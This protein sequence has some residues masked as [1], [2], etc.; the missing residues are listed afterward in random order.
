MTVLRA[1]AKG[2]GKLQLES[3]S[4]FNQPIADDDL[5]H[6]VAMNKLNTFDLYHVK[7]GDAGMIYVAQFPRLKT[8][9]LRTNVGDR[10]LADLRN[11]RQLVWLDLSE[12]PVTDAGMKHLQSLENLHYLN[13]GGTQITDD[14][15]L[16]LAGLSSLESLRLSGG[17][18]GMH[19]VTNVDTK[20]TDKGVQELQK[21]LP[22]CK[23]ER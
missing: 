20:V 4:I 9:S 5:R 19:G 22:K 11:A 17:E 14:G 13:L 7:V 16:A 12:T 8:G 23:I 2:L 3:L 10:G 15:V 21:A 6:L 1:T 18:F